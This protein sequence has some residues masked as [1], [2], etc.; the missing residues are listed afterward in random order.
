MHYNKTLV[1]SI[2]LFS[3]LTISTNATIRFVSSFSGIDNGDGTDK[4]TPVK[5]IQYAIDQADSGDEIHIA[6]YDVESTGGVITTNTCTYTSTNSAVITLS[7]KKSLSLKGGFLYEELLGYW[8]EGIIPPQIDGENTRRCLVAIT[9]DNNTNTIE[10]LEFVNGYTKYDGANIY[11]EDGSLQLIGTPIH[12][13]SAEKN[14]GGVYMKG[15]DFSV[16]MGAYSN[17]ALP[18]MTGLLPIYDNTA[19]NGGG[20]YLDGG[21]PL[22]STLGIVNNTASDNGGGVYINGG[23]PSLVG[24]MIQNNISDGNGG[25]IYLSNSVAR[26]GG[27]NIVSNKSAFGGGIYLDGPFALTMETATLIANNYIRY[28]TATNNEGGGIYFNEA[29]VG[30]V[31]NI[32]ANNTATDGAAAFLKGSSPR[33]LE[34]TIADNTGDTGLYIT[35]S[36]GAGRWIVIHT[37]QGTFSNYVAGIPV[38]SQPTMTNTII[39]GHTTGVY[40]ED[41]GN[42]FL[43]N[44]LDMGYTLWDNTTDIAGSG[45][46]NHTDDL[47]GNP[48]YTGTGMQPTDPTPYHIETNSPAVDSGTEIALSLPGTDLLLDIDAQMRPS[49]DGMDIGADEV[50]TD[51]FSVWFVPS[52][53]SKTVKSGTVVTNIHMLMNSG[54][55]NDTYNLSVSNSLWSGTISPASVTVEAQSYTSVTVTITVPA[56]AADGLTNTTIAKAV[57]QT[58]SNLIAIAIDTTGVSSNAG[59]STVHYV[60]LSSPSPETPY[61]TPSTAAHEIQTAV[62]ISRDGDNVLVYPGTYDT[63]GKVAPS[64]TLTNRVCITNATT[65]KALSGPDDTIIMGAADPVSTNGPGAI[66]GVYI[67]DGGEIHGFTIMDGHTHTN[68]TISVLDH[69]GGGAFLETDVTISNCIIQSCSAYKNGGGIY[70]YYNTYI[71]NSIIEGNHSEIS[72]GGLTISTWCNLINST[73][74]SNKSEANGGG[75]FI[76]SL[77]KTINCSI[78]SNT[79]PWGGGLYIYNSTAT[80]NHIIDNTAQGGGGVWLASDAKLENSIIINNQANVYGGGLYLEMN[81]IVQNCTITE[82]QA[83]TKG[84]GIY[85]SNSSNL[86]N[87][88]I[89]SNNTQNWYCVTGITSEVINY[90]CTD[91]LPAGSGNITNNP[92]FI[93]AAAGDYHIETNSPCIDSGTNIVLEANVDFDNNYRPMD[94]NAD[95]KSTPDMGAY[96]VANENGD[97]DEDGI[98]DKN[99]GVADTNPYDSNS[100]FHIK[101]IT[102]ISNNSPVTVY[103]DSSSNRLY[104]LIYC[105]DLSADSWKFVPGTGLRPGYGVNDSMQDTNILP[106]ASFYRIKVQMTP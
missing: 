81:A 3:L 46:I 64:Y 101:T 30:V 1:S 58:D 34:N 43:A 25:G 9:I 44:K 7:N 24:G 71:I 53:I 6:T 42:S 32:I 26:V 85:I 77:S 15:V 48:M 23:I 75:A 79:A 106:N 45:T 19:Q 76:S 21:Y 59:Q 55:Q 57:S 54:T 72:G 52:A 100:Y 97:S 88:I 83:N 68:G 87:N 94:G 27:M 8:T 12:D 13:G 16:S 41:S 74:R 78:S 105:E 40:I 61:A 49:G 91:P 93:D 80:G 11:A 90:C 73:V 84:D 47:Y 92:Q 67:S 104:R 35:H 70:A 10:L 96:E 39:S 20:L 56:N 66:R 5:T 29:N 31:N 14:G 95:G 38:P 98:S 60:W 62:D 50:V 82:N 69:D 33:F 22:M 102:G 18:Q 99:E 86:Y 103:F 63:G 51:P 65:I 2:I 4:N 17:L 89:Y 37:W 36:T 28:N